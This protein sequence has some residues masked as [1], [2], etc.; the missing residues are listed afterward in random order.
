MPSRDFQSNGERLSEGECWAKPRPLP[1]PCHIHGLLLTLVLHET[2]SRGK[3]W[4]LHKPPGVHLSPLAHVHCA[5][6]R[7]DGDRGEY[8]SQS[9]PHESPALGHLPCFVFMQGQGQS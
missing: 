3:L 7:P 8:E 1:C 9:A 6:G 5:R 4:S 2:K